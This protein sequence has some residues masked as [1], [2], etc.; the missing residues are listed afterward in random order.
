MN[1]ATEWDLLVDESPHESR[2]DYE[3]EL[4]S[5]LPSLADSPTLSILD[6]DC[7]S[8]ERLGSLR[9]LGHEVKLVECLEEIAF[10]KQFDV[11]Y[12]YASFHWFTQQDALLLAVYRA[13]KRGG[14]LLC[15]LGTKGNLLSIREV[16]AQVLRGHGRHYDCPLYLP[17]QREYEQLL[18]QLGFHVVN[19]SSLSRHATL[20]DGKGGMR[21]LLR[22]LFARELAAFDSNSQQSILADTEHLLKDKLFDG[23]DWHADYQRLRVIA[24]K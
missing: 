7:V 13:L 17:T 12:S 8:G 11:V 24:N 16:F 23:K 21:K 14:T 18:K 22:L 15:E 20:P 1:T 2:P 19:I 9:E 3:G 6:V 5:M 10:C 4:L